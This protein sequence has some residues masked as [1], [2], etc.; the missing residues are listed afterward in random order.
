M[1]KNIS[2]S[3]VVCRTNIESYRLIIHNPQTNLNICGEK[4][5]TNTNTGDEYVIM[6]Q[7]EPVRKKLKCDLDRDQFL[8]NPFY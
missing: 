8:L 3:F 7:S 1:V 4:K 2:H 5:L 6:S